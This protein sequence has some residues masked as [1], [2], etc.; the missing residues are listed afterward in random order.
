LG[1]DGALG[2]PLDVGRIDSD[3]DIYP[4]PLQY[5]VDFP[6]AETAIADGGT[7]IPY[8][9]L[10][11]PYTSLTAAEGTIDC[12]IWYMGGI[13]NYLGVAFFFSVVK[14][15]YH[16][17]GDLFYARESGTGNLVLK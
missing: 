7:T 3:A 9:I 10:S 14:I 17:V 5:A 2:A 16:S 13:I 4:I 8:P 15:I 6:I 12:R 11:Y 1:F